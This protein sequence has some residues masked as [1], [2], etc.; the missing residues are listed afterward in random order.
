MNFYSVSIVIYNESFQIRGDI[1]EKELFENYIN[2]YGASLTRLCFLLCGNKSNSED[3]FQETWLKAIKFYD[4]YKVSIPFDKWLYRICINTYRD[5]QKKSD[6]RNKI[7]FSTDDE[8]EIFISSI[9]DKSTSNEQYK[10]LLQ[11]IN[12]LPDKYKTIIALRYF[13]DYSEKDTAKILKIPVGTVKSRLSKA[14]VL[15]KRRLSE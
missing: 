13:N 12:D 2:K 11:C 14:K 7:Q 15:I 5:F 10:E 1:L 8:H 4:K 3:L 6:N 9:Q